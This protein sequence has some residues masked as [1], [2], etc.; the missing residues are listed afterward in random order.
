MPGFTTPV[1]CGN[2]PATPAVSG[3]AV[4]DNGAREGGFGK[5][6]HLIG[7]VEFGKFA[8]TG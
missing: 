3:A 4:F 8:H 6:S 7:F 2:P 1:N 5:I